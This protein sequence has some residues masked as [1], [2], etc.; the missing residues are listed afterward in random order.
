MNPINQSKITTCML[1]NGYILMA[2]VGPTSIFV[3]G[4]SFDSN[5]A[6]I[7]N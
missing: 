6:I 1:E 2:K 4:E 7:K 3:R 5:L